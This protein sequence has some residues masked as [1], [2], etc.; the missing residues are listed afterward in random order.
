LGQGQVIPGESTVGG[1]SLPGETLP[2]RLLALEVASANRTLA[3]LRQA[4]PPVIARTQDERV[5][6]DPRTVLAEQ[7]EVL[8]GELQEALFR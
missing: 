1:G 5:V 8:L 3:R 6:L 2:T 4:S 7:E